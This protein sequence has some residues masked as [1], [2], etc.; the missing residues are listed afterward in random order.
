M[1]RVRNEI[2]KV[3]NE[4]VNPFKTISSFPA[5]KEQVD[6]TNGSEIHG[7]GQLIGKYQL[8]G[9]GAYSFGE[10]QQYACFQAG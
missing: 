3:N 4:K 6:Q 9:N 10:D 8:D 7:I 1:K 5:I 2:D